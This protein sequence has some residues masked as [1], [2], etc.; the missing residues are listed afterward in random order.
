MPMGLECCAL[1][2]GP[3]RRGAAVTRNKEPKRARRAKRKAQ[4]KARRAQRR[5]GR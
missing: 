4:K 2:P 3:E 5:R 1:R